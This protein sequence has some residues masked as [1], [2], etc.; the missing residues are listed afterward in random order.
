MVVSIE[1][2]MCDECKVDER[3]RKR[4]KKKM[5][6]SW[7][8]IKRKKKEGCAGGSGYIYIEAKGSEWEVQREGASECRGVWLDGCKV[9]LRRGG[10]RK[11][12]CGSGKNERNGVMR[13]RT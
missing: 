6:G 3:P 1:R 11:R 8:K 7:M 13:S 2:V 10:G 9:S 12:A 5:V 4:M